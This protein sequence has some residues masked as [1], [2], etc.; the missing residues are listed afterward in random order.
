[1]FDAVPCILVS[2]C[3][4]GKKDRTCVFFSQHLRSA[5]DLILWGCSIT[6]ERIH[7]GQ[8]WTPRT[9]N[10][11][12][13]GS[14]IS[15]SRLQALDQLLHLPDLNVLLSLAGGLRV[16]HVG[17]SSASRSCALS[18]S[19]ST[20]WMTLQ[21][22]VSR[23]MFSQCCGDVVGGLWAASRLYLRSENLVERRRPLVVFSRFC[24]H[25]RSLG[26]SRREGWLYSHITTNLKWIR[27]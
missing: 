3:H 27:Y 11:R 24:P 12:D 9:N 4:E 6:L 15:S 25:L 18:A 5:G 19:P 20:K 16:T 8:I 22:T 7:I 17:G 23:N 2:T 1:M 10:Q 13:H 14:S 26:S 21:V